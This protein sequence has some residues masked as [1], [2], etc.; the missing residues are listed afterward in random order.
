MAVREEA[1][2]ALDAIME[3]VDEG[4]E[5]GTL[6]DSTFGITRQGPSGSRPSGSIQVADV[7]VAGA[8]RE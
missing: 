2:A 7:G 5:E 8:V 3:A 1:A 6:V 4:V